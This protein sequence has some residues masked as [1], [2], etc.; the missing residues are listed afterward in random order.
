MQDL[1]NMEIELFWDSEAPELPKYTKTIW[2]IIKN[3]ENEPKELYL[4][5]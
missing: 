5:C 3:I 1:Q 4:D 2:G